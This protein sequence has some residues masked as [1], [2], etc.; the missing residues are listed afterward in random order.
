MAIQL[1]TAENYEEVIKEGFVI[2]DFFSETCTPC[3]MFSKV[4]DEIEYEVPFVNIVKV[5][6]TKYPELSKKNKVLG[7]P[8]VFFMK[9]GE[10]RERHTGVMTEEEV[11]NKIKGFLY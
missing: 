5:N 11:K 4:L 2:V 6:T 8:T 9:D 3:K 10:I 1:A 7:V